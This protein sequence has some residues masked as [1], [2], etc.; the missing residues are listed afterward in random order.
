MKDDRSAG[1]L[2]GTGKDDDDDDDNDNE[3]FETVA[4]FNDLK[5]NDVAGSASGLSMFEV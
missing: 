2:F 1:A 5:D 4:L 3:Y